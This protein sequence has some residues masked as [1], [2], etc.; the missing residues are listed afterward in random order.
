[1]YSL[2]LLG[3]VSLSCPD[4]ELNGRATQPRQIA[5]L[6]LLAV[7]P[8][9]GISREQISR[10]LW[11]DVAAHRGLRRL[12]DALYLI[13]R[14][15][16]KDA[17]DATGRRLTLNPSVVWS[18]VEKFERAL[19][20]GDL[21]RALQLYRGRFLDGFRFGQSSEFERWVDVQADR[22]QR[23]AIDAAKE[24]LAASEQEGDLSSACRWARRALTID[25][26][27]EPAAR[28][29]VDLLSRKGDRTGAVRA[30]EEFADRLRSD[31]DL[32]PSEETKALVHR[33]RE[34]PGPRARTATTVDVVGAVAVLPLETLG[35]NPGQEVFAAGFQDAL[36]AELGAIDSLRVISR[37]STLCFKDRAAPMPEIARRLGVD[38]VVEGTAFRDG[39]H[40]RIRLKL[41]RA[42][43]QERQLWAGEYEG[44]LENALIVQGQVARAIVKEMHGHLSPRTEERLARARAVNP[45]MYDA[46]LRG[47]Y[48]INTFTPRGFALGIEYLRKAVEAEPTDPLPHAALALG[49][50][51]YGHEAGAPGEFFPS[52]EAAARRALE[53][54]PGS[55]EA[56]EAMAETKLYWE[57]DWVGAEEAFDRALGINPSLALAHAHRGWY[58]HLCRKWEA[59]VASMRRAASLDPLVP[60]FPAWIGWMLLLMDR[61]EEARAEAKRSLELQPDFPVGLYVVGASRAAKGVFDEALEHHRKARQ[62][63][64]EWAWGLAHTATLAGRPDEA[65]AVLADMKE[66]PTGMTHFGSAVVHAALGEVEEGLAALQRA[67]DARFSWVPWI[68]VYPL[69]DGLSNHPRYQAL[70]DEMNAP[71]A[72]EGVTATKKETAE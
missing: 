63:S 55:A 45:A 41:V 71:C 68:S 53:L 30:Y 35:G 23:K 50:S 72:G 65:R 47:T 8:Q 21:P 5:L 26:Y 15:L 40:F 31:L 62:V 38:A 28:A 58:L 7:R 3:T 33:L 22:M 16:G 49:Y 12:S 37:T 60:L 14:A 17:L 46:Y 66:Q 39:E 9:Q 19:E 29:L 48:H 69:M 18:D 6:S 11:P 44:E 10:T 54:D 2:E 70:L 43:P 20:A 42:R 27:D 57:W 64:P 4:G 13:Q 34:Q 67:F 51:Q 59:G 61:P 52:A 25:S 32:Q 1:M 56:H 36:I 24:L